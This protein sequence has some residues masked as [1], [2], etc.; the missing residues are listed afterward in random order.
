MKTTKEAKSSIGKPKGEEKKARKGAPIHRKCI[1]EGCTKYRI[2]KCDRM[3]RKHYTRKHLK[4]CVISGRLVFENDQQKVRLMDEV[5]DDPC[6]NDTDEKKSR[7]SDPVHRKCIVEGCTKYGT[8]KCDR[9]CRNHFNLV[10]NGAVMNGLVLDKDIQERASLLSSNSVQLPGETSSLAGKDKRQRVRLMDKVVNS[11]N[12]DTDEKREPTKSTMKTT[13][14][15]K[16]SIGKP[17]GEEKKAR[18]GAPGRHQCMVEGCTEYRIR[19]CDRMC[20]NHFMLVGNGAV[21][22]GLVLDKDIQERASLLSSNS[23]QLSGET[24]SLAGKDKRQ[25]VRLMDKVVNSCNNDTDEKREPTKSTVKTTK[26]AKSSIG[27]TKGE[28]K[29]ARKGAPGRHKC[30]V[31]GCTEYRIS[32]NDKMCSNHFML[33]GTGAHLYE[34]KEMLEKREPR[35]STKKTTKKAKSSIGKTKGGEKK[36]RT[37]KSTKKT[38]KKAKSPIAKTKGE[39]KKARKGVESCEKRSKSETKMCPSHFDQL[40][41]NPSRFDYDS[42]LAPMKSKRMQCIINGCKVRA[43][44]FRDFALC[45]S[46]GRTFSMHPPTEMKKICGNNTRPIDAGK[47]CQLYNEYEKLY[48]CFNFASLNREWKADEIITP[49]AQHFPLEKQKQFFSIRKQ[50]IQHAKKEQ[51]KYIMKKRASRKNEDTKLPTESS[52]IAKLLNGEQMIPASL[53]KQIVQNIMKRGVN[54]IANIRDLVLAEAQD[55]LQ[56]NDPDRGEIHH[57]IYR[58][59]PITMVEKFASWSTSYGGNIEPAP[60]LMPSQVAFIRQFLGNKLQDRLYSDD[61][62]EDVALKVQKILNRFD[63]SALVAIGISVEEAMTAAMIPLAKAHVK[64]G[65]QVAVIN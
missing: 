33:V 41:D 15:A 52:Q 39:E 12:N 18:K 47:S 16:S 31:E 8:K 45:R 49:T 7:K 59:M 27:K 14:E 23:V 5:V 2:R 1:V 29:K 64:K 19:K 20:S 58:H 3:C 26:E 55:V 54:N 36:A 24:S 53:A 44:T 40:T 34:W 9:M 35:K 46:H 65:Q 37:T 4:Y 60:P 50:I 51:T 25:R 22:N 38:T 32:N 61:G 62:A 43:N 63:P 57:S 28:E 56:L 21:M 17:K 11:C 13:K 10:G 6:N 30:M 42:R 48:K